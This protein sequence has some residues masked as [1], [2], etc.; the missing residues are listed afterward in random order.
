MTLHQVEGPEVELTP[1][2]DEGTASIQTRGRDFGELVGQTLSFRI[3]VDG[4]PGAVDDC[5]PGSDGRA[6]E[7]CRATA[8]ISTPP[9]VRV[10]HLTDAPVASE[11]GIITIAV[12]LENTTECGVQA[13]QYVERLD[14]L[15]FIAGSARFNDRPIDASLVEETLAVAELDLPAKGRG[16]L[17][18]SARPRLLKSSRPAGQ[19]FLRNEPISAPERGFGSGARASVGCGCQGAPI[20]IAGIWAVAWAL[21]LCRVRRASRRPWSPAP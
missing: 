16:V 12:L 7:L 21:V 13:V 8:R 10:T 5:R 18:Y 11:S 2:D 3:A 14:G 15:H 19:A 9:F 17:T 20:G 4:G 1:F 6:L